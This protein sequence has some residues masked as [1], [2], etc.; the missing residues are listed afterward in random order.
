MISVYRHLAIL[1]ALT[2]KNPSGFSSAKYVVARYTTA[3]STTRYL[4]ILFVF[5]V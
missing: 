4:T 3:T 1:N 5:S 2:Q